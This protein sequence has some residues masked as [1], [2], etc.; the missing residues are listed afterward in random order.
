ML[1][2]NLSSKDALAVIAANADSKTVVSRDLIQQNMNNQKIK[3][4]GQIQ[5]VSFRNTRNGKAFAIVNVGL[6]NGAVEVFVWEELLATTREI[7]KDAKP[8]LVSGIVKD[9]G[10]EQVTISASEIIEFILSDVPLNS[11]DK[12]VQN[13]ES[14]LFSNDETE[15]NMIEVQNVN[16]QKPA[17]ISNNGSN[18]N[19]NQEIENSTQQ[20]SHS[21]NKRLLIT[22]IESKKVLLFN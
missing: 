3:I 8:I 20:D 10:E 2:V 19:M 13:L 14:N 5:S 16:N 6:L 9:R 1:G 15:E 4:A 18:V 12:P 11:L 21:L 7:L 22:I 17:P